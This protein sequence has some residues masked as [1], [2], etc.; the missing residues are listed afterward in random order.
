MRSPVLWSSFV[1][2]PLRPQCGSFYS[3]GRLG[4]D[5]GSG[6]IHLTS[7][8]AITAHGS[9]V[10]LSISQFETITAHGSRHLTFNLAICHNHG[11]RK[12]HPTS[13]S[14]RPMRLRLIS[15]A[16]CLIQQGIRIHRFPPLILSSSPRPLVYS[17]HRSHNRFFPPA[18]PLCIT[19]I[20]SHWI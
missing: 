20:Y 17:S 13:I 8:P 5:H 14:G 12:F 6:R 4:Y 10:S 7:N 15:G 11:W 18:V 1:R 3:G 16:T 19:N 9:Y 2:I